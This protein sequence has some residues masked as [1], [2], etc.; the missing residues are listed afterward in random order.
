MNNKR[1]KNI[2]KAV[3]Y[4]LMMIAILMV[5]I[6]FATIGTMIE[7]MAVYTEQ[8]IIIAVCIVWVGAY[9]SFIHFL[10]K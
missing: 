1:E 3:Y 9:A 10:R 7:N 4:G 8:L 6:T 2:A 5:I